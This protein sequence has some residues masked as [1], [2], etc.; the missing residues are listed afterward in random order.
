NVKV[1]V[2]KYYLKP[3]MA[4][5]DKELDANFFQHVPYMEK[6]AKEHNENLASAGSVHVEPMGVYSSK[7]KDLKD[8]PDGA[9]VAIPNDPTNGGRALLLLQK[10]GLISLKDPKNITATKED[11]VDNKKNLQFVELEAAQLPRSLDDVTVAVIN[12]NFALEAN[13][14]PL[15]DALAL[16]DKDS[17]YANI[18]A[19]RSGDQ[20]RPEIKKLMAALQSPEVKKFIEDKYKGAILPA[21]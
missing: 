19:V 6:F 5:N 13:L 4:I 12:T 18:V 21:F 3:N 15:K 20:D 8:L 11:V 1:I 14:N 17:P 2:I 16:E 7:I 10:A 9:K